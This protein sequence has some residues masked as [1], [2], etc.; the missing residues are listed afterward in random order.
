MLLV[1]HII[2]IK[3]I[4]DIFIIPLPLFFS[5][6]TKSPK[7]PGYLT[8]TTHFDCKQTHF[9]CSLAMCSL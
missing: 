1:Q 3:I 9:Q 4:N 8:V 7:F 5:P 2:N 6:Y